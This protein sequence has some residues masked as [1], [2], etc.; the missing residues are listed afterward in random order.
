M[1]AT[2]LEHVPAIIEQAA[3]SPLGLFAL[4]V[5]ALSALGFVFFR[6]AS[7]LAR[8]GIFMMLFAGVAAFGVATLR[9]APSA[10]AA[11]EAPAPDSTPEPKDGST[12]AA[13]AT[14]AATVDGKWIAE[15]T[16]D[17]GE[18]Y[19]EAFAFRQRDGEVLGSASFLGARRSLFDGRLDAD[20]LSFIVRTQNL[21]GEALTWDYVGRVADDRIE[22]VLRSESDESAHA[23]VEF[24][25]VRAE[26]G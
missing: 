10:A 7:E 20:R 14:S 21:D 13:A 1:D 11:A 8:V 5:I 19:R 12:A 23:P 9:S 15:V 17:W 16:Y 26:D 6:G 2:A 24:V 22:F 3:R 18:T 25:A 4:M